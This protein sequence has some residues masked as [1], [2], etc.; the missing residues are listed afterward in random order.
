MSLSNNFS[1]YDDQ[2]ET[3]INLGLCREKAA[4]FANTPLTEKRKRSNTLT[5]YHDRIKDDLKNGFKRM[6]SKNRFPLI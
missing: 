6:R 3:L 4:L 2:Y 5:R 1:L